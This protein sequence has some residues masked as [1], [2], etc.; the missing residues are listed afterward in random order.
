[1][2]RAVVGFA[3]P[4]KFWGLICAY[5]VKMRLA[6]YLVNSTIEG[7]QFEVCVRVDV[8][9]MIGVGG[10]L[11]IVAALFIIFYHPFLVILLY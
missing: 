1:M 11:T 6:I 7:S 5:I 9:D 4:E 8:G 10:S 3:C 2:I